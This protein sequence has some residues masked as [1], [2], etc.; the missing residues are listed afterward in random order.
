VK[1]RKQL[2]KI[3]KGLILMLGSRFLLDTTAIIALQ[4]EHAGLIEILRMAT[5]IFIPTIAV[6]E[7]P[8]PFFQTTPL[9]PRPLA[10]T[11]RGEKG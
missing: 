4:S 3:A 10:P 9:I 5:D 11:L 8:V 7:L 6:G 2:Q 1:W